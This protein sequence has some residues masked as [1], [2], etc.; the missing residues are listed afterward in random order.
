MRLTD[1]L[2]WM[3]KLGS[4]GRLMLFHVSEDES[5]A[6]VFL[7]KKGSCDLGKKKKM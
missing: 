7:G 2:G 5:S 6:V 4:R 1:T 3:V